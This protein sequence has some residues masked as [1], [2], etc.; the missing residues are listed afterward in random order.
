MTAAAGAAAGTAALLLATGCWR[1]ASSPLA[2][3]AVPRRPE[4]EPEPEPDA[5][6]PEPAPA[7]LLLLL[8]EENAELRRVVSSAGLPLPSGC[9]EQQQQPQGGSSAALRCLAIG[10]G[11]GRTCQRLGCRACSDTGHTHWFTPTGTSITA[12]ATVMPLPQHDADTHGS[13]TAGAG[14]GTGTGTGTSTGAEVA[15]PVAAAE[16]EA[17]AAAAAAAGGAVGYTTQGVRVGNRLY[18]F[19]KPK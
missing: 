8:Q 11:N 15:A 19:P 5:P 7:E 18:P 1:L 17:A 10:G 2:P 3:A 16:E 12:R 14:T 6:E 13:Q 4:P 9:R